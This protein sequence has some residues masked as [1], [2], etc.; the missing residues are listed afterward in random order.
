[1]G[2][3]NTNKFLFEIDQHTKKYQLTSFNCKIN[4]TVT[5]NDSILF[6]LFIEY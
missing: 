1:M 3:F 4:S 6:N 5:I 2:I